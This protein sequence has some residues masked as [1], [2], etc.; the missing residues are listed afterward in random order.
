MPLFLTA[1]KFLTVIPWPRSAVVGPEEVAKSASFFPLV[2]FFLGLI[3]VFVNRFL[4]P[5]LASEIL[6]VVLVVILILITGARSLEALA[7][8]WDRL[9]AKKGV[10]GSQQ[11]SG[12]RCVGVCG[13]LAVIVIIALKFRA[14]EV[15]GE[16]RNLGLLLAPVLGR[17]ATVV[18]AYGSASAR[19][20]ADRILVEY[21]R[22]RQLVLAS[23]F[24][25][26]GVALV[27]K[28]L[29]L[30]IALWV[31]LVA[32]VSRHFLHR[33]LGGVGWEN[34]GAVGEMSEALALVLFA[35]L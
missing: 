1:V 16:T 23:A 8:T 22:G 28:R 18:L 34:L 15:M 10:D 2:G 25:L 11:L 33:R 19:P 17:W 4:D 20:E 26:I 7:P 27:A 12:N 6:S 5:Y 21:V 32:L 24:T 31:S 14:I 13:L 30:W 3:L 35:S 9:G 29:G